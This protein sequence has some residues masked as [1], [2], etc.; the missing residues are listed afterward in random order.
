MSGRLA[1]A[2]RRARRARKGKRGPRS[3]QKFGPGWRALAPSG[4]RQSGPNFWRAALARGALLLGAGAWCCNLYEG[5]TLEFFP[6]PGAAGAE[7]QASTQCPRERAFCA[8]GACRE[9]LVDEDCSRG[10]PACVGNV[11]VECRAASDCPNGQACNAVL[12]ACAFACVEPSD[13][14]GQP[15]SRCSSE[16]DLC[17]QCLGD[18]D[19][20][21]RS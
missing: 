10:K 21:A 20:D 3:S 15:T 17:V 4:A 1:R 7:C 8:G 2:A 5:R 13:C 11:C 14:A 19:C 6:E 9:C 16:L 18:D 12:S